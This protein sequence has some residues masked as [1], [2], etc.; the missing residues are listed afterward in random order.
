MKQTNTTQR[1]STRWRSKK[2]LGLILAFLLAGITGLQAQ[3]VNWAT[4]PTATNV[5]V[6]SSKDSNITFALEIQGSNLSNGSIEIILPY[7]G[8]LCSTSVTKNSGETLPAPTWNSG[9]KTLTF[10]GVN[11]SATQGTSYTIPHSAADAVNFP[12]GTGA[13]NIIIKVKD[14]G[15]TELKSQTVPCSYLRSGLLLAGTTNTTT[16][17]TG[18]KLD[19]AANNGIHT[20]GAN[21][22]VTYQLD[23]S[24]T[25]A[26]V[27]EVKLV[28]DV[29][30]G[31]V[32]FSNWRV[33]ATNVNSQVTSVGNL[34]TLTI[35]KT[36]FPGG[37]G[38]DAG[39]TASIYVD[40]TKIY[41][42]TNNVSIYAYFGKDATTYQSKSNVATAAF[43]AKE[44]DGIPKLERGTY[45]VP[46]TYVYDG[47]TPNIFITELKNTGSAP[48]AAIRHTIT[49][50]SPGVVEPFS[51]YLDES[52]FKYSLDGG[53]TWIDLTSADYSVATSVPNS[54]G[55]YTVNTKYRG[56]AVRIVVSIPGE[57]AVAKNVKIQYGVVI[58]P[59]FYI[60][61]IGKNRTKLH[62]SRADE[63]INYRDQCRVGNYA[64]NNAGVYSLG[65]F[66][67][68]TSHN[69]SIALHAGDIKAIKTTDVSFSG[70]I[71]RLNKGAGAYCK[72]RV[73]LPEGVELSNSGINY[74]LLESS[75]GVWNHAGI[76]TVTS[77]GFTTYEISYK[78]TDRPSGAA[79]GDIYTLTLNYTT[80]CSGIS[81]NVSGYS[82]ISF[83]YFP[84]GDV[85][86][87]SQTD[88][89]FERAVQ[90]YN[91][92]SAICYPEGFTYDF[93]IERLTVGLKDSNDDW[94]IDAG[95]LPADKNQID[96]AQLLYGDLFNLNFEGTIAEAKEKLYAI[97]Y[98]EQNQTWFKLQG[99]P[100][101][102]GTYVASDLN[103]SSVSDIP[104]DR[105]TSVPAQERYAY[106]VEISKKSGTPFS[107]NDNINLSFPF[108]VVLS[109]TADVVYYCNF[110]SWSYVSDN[111]GGPD[112]LNPVSFSGKEKYT[113]LT[114]Y[115]VV[116]HGG[117]GG[118]GSFEGEV[119]KEVTASTYTIARVAGEYYTFS[120]FEHRS[121][122]IPNTLKVS[123]VEGYTI[124][125]LNIAI[126]CFDGTGVMGTTTTAKVLIPPKPGGTPNEKEY[127][128]K[129]AFDLDGTNPSKISLPDGYYTLYIYPTLTSSYAL[130][131]G[132]STVS[133][134]IVYE[135]YSPGMNGAR[136]INGAL[137]YI[138]NGSII[139]SKA[140]NTEQPLKGT[141]VSW[142]INVKN[143][144]SGTA[145]DVWLYVEGDV[146]N[147]R[148][149][150]GSNTYT[151]QGVDGLWIRIPSIASTFTEVGTLSVD[152][153]P[154]NCS[155]KD[156]TVYSMFDR[157]LAAPGGWTPCAT[158]DNSCLAAVKTAKKLYSKLPLTIINPESKI[159]GSITPLASTPT[160]FTTGTG[161]YGL[162][163]V[164]VDT[165][166]PV[167]I[168]F[169]TEASIG[170]VDNAIATTYFPKG[171]AY[172]AGSAYL[173]YNGN[174][175]PLAGTA[176]ETELQ[177]LVGGEFDPDQTLT[178][179]LSDALTV[180]STTVL[181]GETT[182]KLRFKLKPT[183]F[184]SLNAEQITASFTGD[185]PCGGAAV[186]GGQIFRS[187]PL[188]LSGITPAYSIDVDLSVSNSTMSCQASENTSVATLEFRKTSSAGVTV[189]AND[190]ISISLPESVTLTAGGIAYSSNVIAGGVSPVSG[191]VAD[192]DISASAVVS[193]MVTWSWKLPKTYYDQLATAGVTTTPTLTYIINLEFNAAAATSKFEDDIVGAVSNMVAMGGSCAPQLGIAGSDSEAFIVNPVPVVTKPSDIITCPGVT[194][195]PPAF[196]GNFADS[197]YGYE[198]EIDNLIGL[199]GSTYAVNTGRSG[200]IPSF[201]PMNTGS[202]NLVATVTV[203]PTY[204]TCA[205]TTA[206]ETFT[207][208][209]YPEVSVTV[210]N[211]SDICLGGSVNLVSTVTA[212]ANVTD[213]VYLESDKI[214]VVSTPASV[215][216]T[217]IGAYT[218][219][220]VGENGITGCVSDTMSVTF[221]VND[222]P[223]V[224]PITLP[225]AACE[226]DPLSLPT[227]TVTAQGTPVTAQIWKLDGV[228]Y[229][230]GDP[231]TYA[232]HNKE[233]TFT[234]ESACGDSIVVVG[235]ITVNAKP[236]VTAPITLPAAICEGNPLSLPTPV[237]TPR[238]TPVTAQVWKL[239]GVV[240][241]SG[242]NL[243][244]ADHNKEL[245]FTAESACGD[246][247]VIVG[248]ITVN[249]KPEVTAPMTLPAAICEGNPLSL[250]TPVV[251]PRG[252]PVTAQIWKLDGVVY[253][254]GTNLTYATHDGAELTFTAE[255][256]CGDSIVVI[257]NI[258]VYQTTAITSQPTIPAAVILP[259]GYIRP[260]D[261]VN[262]TVAAVGHGLT[263]QWYKG[264]VALADNTKFSG[265]TTT[266]LTITNAREADND[267]YYVIVSGTCNN[268]TSN[269]VII[270]VANEDATLKDLKVDGTTLYDFSPT[271]LSYT[272]D[273]NCDQLQ[274]IL[275]GTPNFAG[276]TSITGNG[277]YSLTPGDNH[278]AITV[279]A[280]DMVTTL[281]YT[282]N[283]I[284]DCYAPRV[285]KDLE[286]AVICVGD[287]HTFEIKAEGYDLTYEWYYG[288]TQILG[289]NS[290]TYTVTNA[291][292]GDYELYQVIIR[293]NFS[294]FKASA[295]SRK[296]RLWVANYLPTTLRFSE[297]PNPAFV[298]KTHHIKLDGY[299]DVT[300]YSWSFSKD[301]VTFSP[302][303]GQ[304]TENET[305]ATFA[306]SSLGTGT[307]KA[308]LEHPCGTK[309]ATQVI[310]VKKHITGVEDVTAT[311]VTVYP[312]PTTGILKV[313]GTTANETI[314]ISDVSGSLKGTFNA[315]EGTTIIDITGYAKG[316]YML[317]YNGKTHKVIKK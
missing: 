263:Y 182:A 51:H 77:G 79:S 241:T 31:M 88:I 239:D 102:T 140:S 315:Q 35:K 312:N 223:K 43:A 124:G 104:I 186:S 264:G 119:T 213:F 301:G 22:P 86:F 135:S 92:I 73:V 273:V 293:S 69:P 193:G 208:T 105:G 128:L 7:A 9:T 159:S 189:G 190:Y 90:L 25:D 216:P 153:S 304:A 240:Y 282:V 110:S 15:G 161:S 269:N 168:V 21:T 196:T 127:D 94:R 49:A 56:K 299:T 180:L 254:P 26:S 61:E 197:G 230:S 12:A 296:A 60:S 91:P 210:A 157:D 136:S 188:T 150:I 272:T 71:S 52:T 111:I 1:G 70:F 38:L 279:V 133:T 278:L 89:V 165:D 138:D 65:S 117:W 201:I 173:E 129:S 198:W 83:D 10:S 195:T 29:A 17:Q 148:I 81:E 41:C 249:A 78:L 72:L 286:D 169:S 177:K 4:T 47:V 303:V 121:F 179:N 3:T 53:S 275:L 243:T 284:R 245:T 113:I 267:T 23:L 8:E 228:V 187:S 131:P 200:D 317:Q 211:P 103:I 164:A 48:V 57:L 265:T 54:F 176:I 122:A 231:L 226:G 101:V 84:T 314:K 155:S 252:T 171:L 33:G 139:L 260:G 295:Y 214:T 156:I 34:T 218:Y 99:N 302:A 154:A 251:T 205:N 14:S 95:A 289:A 237:V 261:N 97:V 212:S 45:T 96:H 235:N 311:I 20:P 271:K 172:V 46:A 194:I 221:N 285:L 253:T 11:I 167:E 308:T 313:S 40:V 145:N 50:L 67:G 162:S 209:V 291:Q 152:Y 112:P 294:G 306:E 283:I 281:T 106:V 100:T 203:T 266:T 288:S 75:K 222:K 242:T 126:S 132:N 276:V 108:K 134:T 307:L 116:V 82:D 143:T 18:F 107:I 174:F 300:K 123:V 207:I 206:A 297:Y 234:A 80:N 28:F 2:L 16:N 137:T 181:D 149:K 256:A 32:A 158:L 36:D 185:R 146:S 199:D 160:N 13:G 64:I 151:G 298:G 30:A 305:W 204:G 6:G 44:S 225:A 66:M 184:V 227:P 62:I 39:E 109:S 63:Q 247:T 76:T 74:A 255:S 147:A 141:S 220:I 42:S 244:Y 87:G 224:E 98:A 93:S 183:C 236:E 202:G 290:N 163:T 262:L 19:F 287:T 175:E 120:P 268:V 55:S 310:E 215:T 24:G 114:A 280:Q 68:L 37:D 233:L 316:T 257:G 258:T 292:P 166:F 144:K 219:Y 277:T 274:A 217:A 130:T 192:M 5:S 118:S 59:D 125:A 259:N 250:P 170:G 229:N 248:N 85:V 27:D 309:E 142:D 178:L 232:D 115:L 270:N 191:T 58:A 238:G 246:S